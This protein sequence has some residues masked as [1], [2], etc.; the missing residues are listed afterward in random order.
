MNYTVITI[1]LN[2]EETL[3]KT[4]DSVIDQSI[5][6]L[7]Y[8]FV[9]GGSTDSTLDIINNLKSSCTEIDLSIL[10]QKEK[11]GIYGAM[12]L[13]V[14]QAS[15]DIIFILNSDDWLEKEATNYVI[16][17]FEKDSSLELLYA[18]VYFHYEKGSK[19]LRTPRSLALFPFLMPLAHP[20]TFIRKSVYDK[21]GYYDENYKLSADYEFVYRCY[22]AD[23]KF[24]RSD[25][26]L[27]NMLLG[28]AA[29]SNRDI[30]RKETYEIGKKYSCCRILPFMSY[31][32]RWLLKR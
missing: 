18:P 21:M 23:I 27:V 12:N 10:H 26:P 32:I 30:A 11:S 2:S 17:E 9:D 8:I 25:F 6:P 24:R 15:G 5:L 14:K 1:C 22:N 20:G 4:I 28:G 7:E 3:Q 16:N 19:L 31:I 29:N 13:G